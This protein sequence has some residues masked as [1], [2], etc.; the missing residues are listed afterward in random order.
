MTSLEGGWAAALQRQQALGLRRERDTVDGPQGT[1]VC[2]AG[3]RLVNFSSNDYLGLANHPEVA[4]ALIGGARRYG[5]GAGA[6]H[7]ISGHSEAHERLEEELAVFV[8]RERSLLFSTGYMANLGAITALA[9][10]G[11]EVFEDRYNHA[12]LLDGGVLSRAKLRRYPHADSSALAEQLATSGA[13][14]KLVVSD[15]V[16]SM[17]G[18]IVPLS[19]LAAVCRSSGA[20]LLIDDA[21]GLGVLGMSGA[22]TL[23]HCGASSDDVPV[24]IGT[25]GKAIGTFGAFVAGRGE[26]IEYLLQTARTY[27]YTT[28]LPPALAEATRTALYLARTEGWRRDR[29]TAL[30]ARF[31]AGARTLGVP[32]FDSVTPIQAVLL[33]GNREVT[34]AAQFLRQAGFWVGAIRP[35]TVPKGTARLR[36]TFSAAHEE[37][38]VDALLAALARLPGDCR[39]W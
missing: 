29:L 8:G 30:V 7:L 3:R 33:N 16:F 32:L 13:A 27:R 35:P 36:I 21:H 5:V 39:S 23:E 26:L 17:E 24:L 25:L 34:A 9:G 37:Q 1:E 4:A 11:A 18:D 19:Q 28:A 15:G 2:V 12:S 6:S 22:G 38:Q 14:M 10:R 20:C 31:R